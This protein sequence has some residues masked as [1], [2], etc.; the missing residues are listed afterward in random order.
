MKLKHKRI[1]NPTIT[2]ADKIM[3]TLA[4]CIRAIKGET[5]I[6]T[7]KDLQELERIVQATQHGRHP[8]YTELPIQQPQRQKQLPR[9]EGPVTR[10]MN[11]SSQQNEQS[12]PRVQ[13]V[14]VIEEPTVQEHYNATL[15]IGQTNAS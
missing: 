6:K 9:V 2:T 10:S 3:T 14:N 7:H 15:I 4:D 12:L 11:I 1:K 5:T 13:D 8:E